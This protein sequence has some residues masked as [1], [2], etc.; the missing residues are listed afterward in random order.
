MKGNLLENSLLRYGLLLAGCNQRAEEETL[1]EVNDGIV[2]GLEI[3]RT[4]L[5]GREYIYGVA[6][7]APSSAAA[8]QARWRQ[9]LE[10]VRHPNHSRLYRIAG[11]S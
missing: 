11:P 7:P 9:C 8:P 2:I 4:D 6:I 3:V 5:R 10:Q 1:A